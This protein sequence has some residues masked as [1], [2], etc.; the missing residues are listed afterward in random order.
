LQGK[1]VKRMPR[2]LNFL[3]LIVLSVVLASPNAFAVA[4]GKELTFSKTNGE[5]PVVFSGTTHA[6]KGVKCTECHPK[7]FK[8]KTGS[9]TGG[10]PFTMKEMEKGKFCGA[11]HNGEKAFSVADKASCNK[12]HK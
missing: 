11:C 7:V 3:I 4:K 6:D 10:A 1:E 12:C 9:T 8:M 2:A 5:K